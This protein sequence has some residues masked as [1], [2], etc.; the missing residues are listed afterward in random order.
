M[1]VPVNFTNGQAD[2]MI[3]EWEEFSEEAVEVA[4]ELRKEAEM[5]AVKAQ[6]AEAVHNAKKPIYVHTNR[7]AR[8]PNGL[9]AFKLSEVVSNSKL[10]PAM[11]EYIKDHFATEPVFTAKGVECGLNV[12]APESL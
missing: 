10:L 9:V 2:V 4:K 6:V 1:R 7:R 11:Y 3:L 8:I 5:D 12:V